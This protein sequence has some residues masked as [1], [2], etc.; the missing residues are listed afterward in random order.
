MLMEG[1]QWNSTKPHLNFNGT[2]RKRTQNILA[3]EY[4]K[5]HNK[6]WKI[7]QRISPMLDKVIVFLT[8]MEKKKMGSI[9]NAKETY[10][11][12]RTY[13]DICHLTKQ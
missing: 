6:Y 8:S 7:L 1:E 12:Q 3:A 10:L 5:E 9:E 2:R 13:S 11:H 4:F